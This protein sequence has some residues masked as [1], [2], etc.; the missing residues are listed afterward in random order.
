MPAAIVFRVQRTKGLEHGVEQALARDR[1]RRDAG[2]DERRRP[3]RRRRRRAGRLRDAARDRPRRARQRPRPGPRHP[4]RPGGGGRGRSPPAQTPADRRR[5]GQRQALPRHRQ[6]RL[7]LGSQPD[8]QRDEL[9]C[10]AT[11]STPTRRCGRCSAGSRPA[12]R[13]ASTT[14]AT[15]SPAT[16]SRSPTTGP[17][18]AACSS[19]PDAELDDG[20]FDIVAVG[21]VGKLRFLGNLPKV[22]K[23][24]HVEDDEV[25]VFRALAPRAERQPALRRLRRRRAPHRP[26]RLAARPAARPERD[27]AAAGRGLSGSGGACSAPSVAAGAGDRRRQ[28]GQRPRRRARP[29]PGRVLLRLAP[30]AIARLGA[31]LERGDRRSSAPPTARPRP[32]G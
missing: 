31:G 25:R 22:F 16:R 21:E 11:S 18:A 30:D 4:R 27:R 9:R 15:A 14:S 24:T 8:R 23:G 13:S 1:S 32:R 6:R 26:A 20:E 19:R 28:P 17:S 3:D 10:A 12:S 2:G 7:R 29:C 5:R